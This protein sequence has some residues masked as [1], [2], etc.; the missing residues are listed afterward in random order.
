MSLNIAT[1]GYAAS[2]DNLKLKEEKQ[3]QAIVTQK[4][5]LKADCASV[6]GGRPDGALPSEGSV[7]SVA[8]NPKEAPLPSAG[9]VPT[10][11]VGRQ[12]ADLLSNDS[13]PSAEVYASMNKTER[14]ELVAAVGILHAKLFQEG[15]LSDKELGWAKSVLACLHRKDGDEASAL[16]TKVY[17]D[18]VKAARTMRQLEQAESLARTV[19]PE[20]LAAGEESAPGGYER[21]KLYKNVIRKTLSLMKEGKP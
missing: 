1:N 13:V 21:S 19:Y 15:A 14:L 12:G 2:K 17:R 9:S 3:Q 10:V 16:I 7:P 11:A 18:S 8:V 5:K 4:E 20:M 6:M